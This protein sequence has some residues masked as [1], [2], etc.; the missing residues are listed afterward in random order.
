VS[1]IARIEHRRVGQPSRRDR[2]RRRYDASRGEARIQ[3]V[4]AGSPAEKSL[5]AA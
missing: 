2:R 1:R 3:A 4:K 5:V